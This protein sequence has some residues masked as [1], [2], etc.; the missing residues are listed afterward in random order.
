VKKIL[1]SLFFISA[2]FLATTK[3]DAQD[4]GSFD[5]IMLSSTMP[6]QMP[7]LDQAP[8]PQEGNL[9]QPGYWSYD[10]NLHD[11]YWVPG[12]WVTP[13]QEGMLWTPG[14]WDQANGLYNYHPGYWGTDVGFYGGV[15]YGF[16]YSGLGY[17]GGKWKHHHFHYNT[18][19]THIDKKVVHNTYVDNTVVDNNVAVSHIS[20][21]GPGGIT[22]RLRPQEERAVHELHI[23]PTEFQIE[24][25]L[26]ARQNP[27][28]FASFNHGRPAI[29]YLNKANSRSFLS[30]AR[31]STG[32]RNNTSAYTPGRSNNTGRSI[33]PG[34][35]TNSGRYTNTSRHTSTSGHTSSHTSS[36]RTGT[37][38]SSKHLASTT[39][40]SSTR[41]PAKTSF[42]S[43]IH[44]V[45]QHATQFV[46]RQFSGKSTSQQKTQQPK[47]Q[48]K[49][50]PRK[51]HT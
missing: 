34:R 45:T 6:P 40:N 3:T 49:V 39:H 8:C 19:V 36:T 47:T 9:W 28:Q 7:D 46:S 41:T 51:T 14:Y 1:I 17:T 10:S 13:P 44:N 33:S 26:A 16:G 32:G 48:P 24:H 29:T 43:K 37:S 4:V 5:A 11:Y 27:G 42:G 22:I 38:G 25:Q 30:A 18:A 50:Q 20:F 12:D 23:P 35:S 31:N 2:L 15:Y 21:N